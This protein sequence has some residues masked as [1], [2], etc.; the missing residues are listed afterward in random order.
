MQKKQITF[1]LVHV[2]WTLNTCE[3]NIW[4][5]FYPVCTL[6]PSLLARCI[7]RVSNSNFSW[8]IIRC[9]TFAK[10]LAHYPWGGGAKTKTNLNLYEVSFFICSETLKQVLC[11]YANKKTC[12]RRFKF[13]LVCG[14][15]GSLNPDVNALS[16]NY[17]RLALLSWFP[18]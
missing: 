11:F 14:E 1:F 18:M 8:G 7:Y 3:Q 16:N 15:R 2:P 10:F 5:L 4:V 13:V 9:E 12:C 17:L 6:F